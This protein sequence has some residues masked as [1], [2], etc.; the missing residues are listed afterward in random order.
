MTVSESRR[1]PYG[2]VALIYL[3]GDRELADLEPETRDRLDHITESESEAAYL[4]RCQ[5]ESQQ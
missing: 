4:A 3:R 2:L 1:L 5:R